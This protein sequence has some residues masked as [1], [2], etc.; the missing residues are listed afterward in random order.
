M[1]RIIPDRAR[2]ESQIVRE[3]ATNSPSDP[4]RK[5]VI[6]HIG[7]E[8]TG[9]SAIQNFCGR[10]AKW[11]AQH[12][13]HYPLVNDTPQHVFIHTEL[14]TRNPQRVRT[15]IQRVRT[16]IDE[17][18]CQTIV[19]SHETLHLDDPAAIREMLD[20][21]DTSILAYVR[22]PVD[23]VISHFATLIRYG[24]LPS[25]NLPKAVRFY[26]KNLL[27]CFDY[28]WALENFAACFGR[29]NLTVRHY[30]PD[31]LIGNQSVT[32][33]LHHIGLAEAEGS[34]WP[35]T[36]ANP[37]IDAD[38]LRIV[39]RI[40][41]ATPGLKPPERKQLARDLYDKLIK[42]LGAEPS[43]PAQRFVSHTLRQKLYNHYEPN[44]QPLYDRY[45][46]G[47]S[48][49]HPPSNAPRTAD[50]AQLAYERTHE[51]ARVIDKAKLVPPR[52]VKHVIS[53]DPFA[54]RPS[55]MASPKIAEPVTTAGS[56]S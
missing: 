43:R 40:T 21:C 53:R 48:I 34:S 39:A 6:M 44:L 22:N 18:P 33:F 42:K 20:G 45:F 5:R 13:I 1:D 37:S 15:L 49:F 4:A 7:W 28:Y 56:P 47:Q 3:H 16:I 55:T 27:A 52:I 11:L 35:Q 19:F 12:G 26:R 10:N 9:T 51:I 29:D 32:D 14:A 41:R 24:S 2:I 23:A 46:N 30:H 54:T 25:H 31:A 36:R 17:S 8:K 38:M 50:D